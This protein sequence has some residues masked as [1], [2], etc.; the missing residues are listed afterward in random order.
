MIRSILFF[1]KTAV[2]IFGFSVLAVSMEGG[3]LLD[4]TTSSFLH[5]LSSSLSIDRIETSNGSIG[6]WDEDEN[7]L[8]LSPRLSDGYRT[9]VSN[10]GE[11]EELIASLRTTQKEEKPHSETKKRKEHKQLEKSQKKKTVPSPGEEDLSGLSQQ[12]RDLYNQIEF[13]VEVGQLFKT[14]LPCYQWVFLMHHGKMDMPNLIEKVG[15]TEGTLRAYKGH[16]T[17]VGILP[18]TNRKKT[19]RS[20]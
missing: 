10:A 16:L 5:P 19:E 12:Q 2:F 7:P 18:S 9:P 20:N 8:S 6:S 15:H 11:W 4:R 13:E 3:E 1:T 14:T 17:R